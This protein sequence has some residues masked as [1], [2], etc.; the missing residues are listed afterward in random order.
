ML[1]VGQME[2]GKYVERSYRGDTEDPAQLI[3]AYDKDEMIQVAKEI[4]EDWLGD[5]KCEHEH[6]ICYC[7]V[8]NWLAAASDD[9]KDG[10][11]V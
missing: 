3:T 2:N 1:T 6:G 8:F 7:R 11:Y 10:S 9:W 4:I 5:A